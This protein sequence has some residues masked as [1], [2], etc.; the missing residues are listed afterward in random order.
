MTRY[1][2]SKKIY[3]T[4][5]ITGTFTLRSGTVSNEYFDKYLF[6][7]D[8]VLFSAIADCMAELI[9]KETEVLAGLEMGGIPIATALSLKTGI[10]CAF[11]R[12]KAKTYGT[13]KLA[14][15]ASV[16]GKR[17]CII[18]DVVTTGGQIIESTREL[19]ALGADIDTVLCA[20]L[21]EDKAVSLLKAEG[22]TLKAAFTMEELSPDPKK[23]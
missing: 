18:E 12:K 20:I 19:R 3:E 13:C 17:V 21:R 9:P 4:S 6:E 16:S 2:L 11:V 23:S 15:G 7:A 5:H 8:P 22:L 1:E 10:P 14:E